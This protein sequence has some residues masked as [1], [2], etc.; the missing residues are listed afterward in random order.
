MG[1]LV[2][3]VIKA[4]G[5]QGTAK[6]YNTYYEIRTN[7]YLQL[8]GW[9]D[10]EVAT[11]GDVYKHPFA[12]LTETYNVALSAPGAVVNGRVPAWLAFI[13]GSRNRRFYF[14]KRAI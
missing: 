10:A 11:F 12:A 4:S 6:A 14:I 9:T 1:N 13:K 2:D 7:N 3:W 8:K 5:L